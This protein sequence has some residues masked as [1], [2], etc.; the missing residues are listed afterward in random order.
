MLG[1]VL[2]K[3]VLG[4]LCSMTLAGLPGCGAQ[5]KTLPSEPNVCHDQ[6]ADGQ[7][8]AHD[9]GTTGWLFRQG[10]GPTIPEELEYVPEGYTSPAEHP[11][12]LEG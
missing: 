7:A 1:A 3:L 2:E 4:V 5:S 8:F 10:G 12:T 6:H 11:G 9:E